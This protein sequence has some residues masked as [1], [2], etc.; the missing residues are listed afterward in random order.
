MD[1]TY[2]L[3]EQSSFTFDEE[4]KFRIPPDEVVES[5]AS[6]LDY[7]ERLALKNVF[8]MPDM[9]ETDLKI[10]NAISIVA[11]DTKVTPLHF[12]SL[13]RVNCPLSFVRGFKRC[14]EAWRATGLLPEEDIPT[15][16]ELNQQLEM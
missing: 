11:Q 10:V 16:E 4:R 6:F 15:A 1:F 9:S 3:M 7:G 2:T 5:L 13:M 14:A 8:G 12:M